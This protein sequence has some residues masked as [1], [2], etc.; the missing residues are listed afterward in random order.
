MDLQTSRLIQLKQLQYQVIDNY[1]Q[2]LGGSLLVLKFHL[3]GKSRLKYILYTYNFFNT[4]APVSIPQHN[5]SAFKI[6]VCS[7]QFH[8]NVR[9]MSVF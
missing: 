4:N 2:K 7:V 5:I 1:L 3:F 6:S 8:N 9:I